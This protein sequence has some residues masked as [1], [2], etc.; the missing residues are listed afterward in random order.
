MAQ[1]GSPADDILMEEVIVVGYRASLERALNIKRNSS[2][3]VDAINSEDIGKLPDQNVAE[4]LQRVTGVAIARSRGEGDFVSIRG[5]GPN[6]VRGTVNNRTLVSATESRDAIR[7]GAVESSTG[8]EVNLDLLP[9]EIISTLEVIKSPAAEHVEGGIGGVVNIGTHRPF[10]LGHRYAGS[11]RGTYREFNEETD[12]AASGIASWVDEDRVFGILGA[13]S[14]SERS[15]RDDNMDSFG[16]LP[17]DGAAVWDTDGDGTGDLANPQLVSVAHPASYTEDRERLT[18]QTA[19]QWALDEDSELTLDV[20]YSKRDVDNL[21]LLAICC[22]VW[23]ASSFGE[24]TNPDGSVRAPGAARSGNSVTGYD[25]D[26]EITTTTDEQII[27][28]ELVGVGLEYSLVL[29]DWELN[30]N[31][32]F[33]RA[34]G[35]LSFQ[36]NSLRTIDEVSH[37]IDISGDVIDPVLLP[38]G[39]DLS[40]PASWQTSNADAV[41]RKNEDEELSFAAAAKRIIEGSDFADALKFGVRLRSRDKDR[42]DSTTFNV[43]TDQFPA[44]GMDR[45]RRSDGDFLDGGPSAGFD[46]LLFSDIATQ[47]AYIRSQ[48][49]D[50]SFDAVFSASQSYEISEDTFAGFVQL[51]L[52]GAIGNV[53]FSGN[54]GVRLVHTQQDITGF[55]QPFRIENLED[56]NNLG[57]VVN[58]SDEISRNTTSSNYTNILPSLNLRFSLTDELLLRTSLNKSVTRPTFAQLAPGLSGINPTNRLTN[59]GNPELN[60][61]ESLNFDVGLEWYFDD[62]SALYA[63]LFSKRIEEFIGTNTRVCPRD[64]D[65]DG[66][67]DGIPDGLGN[68][69]ELF[70]VGFAS[71]SLPENQGEADIS[72]IE[73]GYQHAF[74]S[75][76]G[77]L[78]N[79]TFIDSS[80]KFISGVNEG[81]EIPFEGVSDLS[82]NVTGYYE[83]GRLRARLAWSYRDEFVLPTLSSDVFGNTLFADEYGQLDASVSYS[84]NDAYTVFVNAL[85]L[86]DEEPYIYSDTPDHPV[87]LSHIGPRLEF[88]VRGTF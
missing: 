19:L 83:K 87:S 35:D 1:S 61:Y 49:P 13:V 53:P 55:F 56:Q 16:Y 77:Y 40:N 42:T 41:F 88:G 85:N 2:E 20:L 27:E 12:P 47:R 18:L 68:C 8:R 22:A 71:V 58:L 86:T 25:I 52:A 62:A 60:A 64:Q 6:F 72:G 43:N 84:F 74:G 26:A 36:R 5:L 70:G 59:A 66:D 67:G 51:D 4:A 80:A 79:A 33:S 29:A 14:W 24:G 21:G 11:V 28:D 17:W 54:L 65:S 50:A 39:P 73:V 31:A 45:F 75:G 78:L 63:T 69:V 46:T 44:A 76:F 7:S 23:D 34:T 9:S 15:L 57:S 48:N 37:R 32:D 38:G 10:D 82:Y 3:F 30:F 81:Q